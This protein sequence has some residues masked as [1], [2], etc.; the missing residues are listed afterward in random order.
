M[1]N[2][3]YTIRNVNSGLWLGAENNSALQ[4]DTADKWN[5]TALGDGFYSV[6]SESGDALTVQNASSADGADIVLS[7]YTNDDS[8]KF[9]FYANDDGSYSILSA[10]S[11]N[12]SGLDVYG[13]SLDAG[14]NIC[15]WNYWGGDGQ[16]FILEPAASIAEKIRGDINADG[17]FDISDAVLLQKWLLAAPDTH[18]ADWEAGDLCEDGR[19]DAF[20]FCLMKRML[21]ENS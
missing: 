16:K 5:I 15:Q 14:A 4:T 11:G 21:I 1:S 2:G 20:D 9:T 17:K 6:Q 13:I 18:L 7:A 3:T 12:K 8:Q 10:I 19:L